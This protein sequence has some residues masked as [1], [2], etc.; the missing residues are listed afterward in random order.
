MANNG[1]SSVHPSSLSPQPLIFT[2]PDQGSVFRL[3]PNIPADKQK[4]RVS[5]R[6]ADGVEVRQV[7]LLVNG[8]PLADG[9]ETLWQMTPGSY[10]FEA[11][12]RDAA[13]REI[14]AGQV[15]VKVVE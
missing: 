13:G 6:P 7:T 14:R 11:I 10:T 12:G 15:T 3:T 1:Q 2:S 4:I 5:V 9:P 8:R